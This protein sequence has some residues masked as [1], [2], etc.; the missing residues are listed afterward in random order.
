MEY[1]E[2]LKT[3]AFDKIMSLV[4]FNT[5]LRYTDYYRNAKYEQKEILDQ[6]RDFVIEFSG[7]LKKTIF[8][9]KNVSDSIS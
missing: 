1:Y 7:W 6:P 9:I 8:T 5:K 2:N 4:P 3:E